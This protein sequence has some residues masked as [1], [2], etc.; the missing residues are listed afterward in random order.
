MRRLVA[1]LD[2]IGD[3]VLA[4]PA[5]R[6]L[7]NGADHV[8]FLAGPAGAE[9]ARLLPGVDQVVEFDAPWV[10]LDPRPFVPE[11]ASGLVS[12]VQEERID[13]AVIL[14]SFHQSPLPLALLL[15]AAGVGHIV[16]TSTDYPGALLDVRV[17]YDNTLHEVEQSL[18]TCREGGFDLPQ[19]D[20][21]ALLLRTEPSDVG[22]LPTRPFVVIHPGAS[23]PARALPLA[24]LRDLV[25][26]LTETD[27][28]V[29]LTGTDAELEVA[30]SVCEPDERVHVMCGDTTVSEF[31][32]LIGRAQVVVCGNTAAAHIAA[33]MGTPVVQAFAPVVPAH[34]WYPWKVPHVLLGHLDIGCAGCRSRTCPVDGQPCLAPFDTKSAMNAVEELTVG[35][36]AAR[37]ELTQGKVR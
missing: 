22:W 16:A 3:V 24:P 6:A 28:D 15:R 2:N 25:T 20:D 5:V 34:R 32:W 17:S 4:G 12:R 1:R 7:A 8:M 36:P 10:P 18:L 37:V 14:T 31:A 29:V 30:R 23:V 35:A 11:A 33:A 27:R 19:S 13:E 21:G 9:T 26:A